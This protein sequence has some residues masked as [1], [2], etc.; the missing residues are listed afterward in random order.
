MGR[1]SGMSSFGWHH[2]AYMRN[3][4]LH[5]FCSAAMQFRG[6]TGYRFET[7]VLLSLPPTACLGFLGAK[8]LTSFAGQAKS[9]RLLVFCPM[10]RTPETAV[11]DFSMFCDSEEFMLKL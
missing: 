3:H 10:Q 2:G 5:S 11:T 7:Y 1:W 8:C 9:S 6:H 4:N